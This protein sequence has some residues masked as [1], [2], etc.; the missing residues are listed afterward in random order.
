MNPAQVIRCIYIEEILN[1]DS[2]SEGR[3]DLTFAA[4]E[5][6]ITMYKIYINK[7]KPLCFS[8]F[9]KQKA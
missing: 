1:T 4:E 7:V 6:T 2:F 3:K 5:K 9:V 8:C